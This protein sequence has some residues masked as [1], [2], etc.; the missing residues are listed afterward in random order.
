MGT[1]RAVHDASL[2]V[3][4]MTIDDDRISLIGYLYVSPERVLYGS[5]IAMIW[6][7]VCQYGI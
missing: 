6:H 7:V 5:L 3:W 4:P 1:D 2:G